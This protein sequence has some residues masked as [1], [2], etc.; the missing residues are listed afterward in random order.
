MIFVRDDQLYRDLF[1][2]FRW[3]IG[4]QEFS[5]SIGQTGATA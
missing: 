3:S 2:G 1:T 4:G 5:R